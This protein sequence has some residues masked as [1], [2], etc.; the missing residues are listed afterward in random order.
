MRPKAAED[1]EREQGWVLLEALIA[2]V[3]LVGFLVGAA[4]SM[5]WLLVF[6]AKLRAAEDEIL[7]AWN[8]AQLWQAERIETPGLG[9]TVPATSFALPF[10]ECITLEVRSGVNWT[11]CR[12]K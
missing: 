8:Q 2:T 5:G 1:R 3:V 9:P 4:G 6:E 7:R 10:V 12:A 11:V